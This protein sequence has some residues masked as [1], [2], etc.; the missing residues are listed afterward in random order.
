MTWLALKLEGSSLSIGDLPPT[1]TTLEA[2]FEDNMNGFTAALPAPIT[3]LSARGYDTTLDQ[4]FLNDLPKGIMD[5]NLS[6]SMLSGDLVFPSSLVKLQVFTLKAMQGR[7]PVIPESVHILNIFIPRF[8][9]I[10]LLSLPAA[11]EELNISKLDDSHNFGFK[12]LEFQSRVR[13]LLKVGL[14]HGC[15]DEEEKRSLLSEDT[16]QASMLSFQELCES[17][18]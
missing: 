15:L 10:D 3:R 5:L 18:I 7:L 9:V 17:Y 11:L 16:I 12:N 13:Q 6:C 4:H 2:T 1:L 14:Q 8:G